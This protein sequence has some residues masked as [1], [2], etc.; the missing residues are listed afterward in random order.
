MLE[1]IIGL[2]SIFLASYT[3]IISGYF[4]S[5]FIEYHFF[6]EPTKTDDDSYREVVN[7][8]LWAIILT[9]AWGIISIS[10]AAIDYVLGFT[11]IY[12]GFRLME[13]ES[14]LFSFIWSFLVG[15]SSTIIRI[16][17]LAFAAYK[18]DR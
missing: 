8:I 6:Y 9:F 18:K 2:K 15:I 12:N 13:N 4:L 3:G 1:Y 10:A 11:P 17:E 14:V 7:L 16:C 5:C